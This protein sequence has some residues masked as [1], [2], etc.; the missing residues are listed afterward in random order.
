[1]EKNQKKS[2]EKNNIILTTKRIKNLS[3][4]IKE[5]KKDCNI[6]IKNYCKTDKKKRNILMSNNRFENINK[7]NQNKVEETLAIYTLQNIPK[8][9]SKENKGIQNKKEKNK[10]QNSLKP[11]NMNI[12]NQSKFHEENYL[13]KRY[14]KNNFSDIKVKKI[15]SNFNSIILNFKK[16]NHKY[17]YRLNDNKIKGN[18]TFI[19]NKEL[20][21]QDGKIG[22]SKKKQNK[23]KDCNNKKEIKTPFKNINGIN[24]G[25]FKSF[26][27]KKYSVSFVKEPFKIEQ[28]YNI[29]N[30]LKN[31]K[32]RIKWK[33]KHL[34]KS[35]E[36]K[37]FMKQKIKNNIIFSH[38]YT[39]R[40]KKK[41]DNSSHISKKLEIDKTKNLLNNRYQRT[42]YSSSFHKTLPITINKIKF[43]NNK[44]EKTNSFGRINSHKI[45][46]TNI[47][48]NLYKENENNWLT[49]SNEN[50]HIN[51]YNKTEKI[52]EENIID[53]EKAYLLEEKVFKIL[54][55]INE[56]IACDEECLN[57]I[58]F[59][60]G[61]NFYI[62]ELNLFKKRNNYKKIHNYSK[63]EIL[64]YCLCYDISLN[65]NFNKASILLKSII[66]ILHQNFLVLLEYFLYLSKNSNNNENSKNN[67]WKGKIEKIIEK[68]LKINL[69][70]QDLN[71][72]SITHLIFN[73]FK[74]ICNYY[75]MIID[76]L[77]SFEEN[78]KNKEDY[79]P[80]CLSLN[81]NKIN[82]KKKMNIISLFFIEANK[83]LNNYTFENMK[84][85]FYL[86]LN[87]QKYSFI[88][89]EQ[90][91][92]INE[93]TKFTKY[94]LAPIKQGFKYTLIINLDETLIYNDNNKIILRPNLFNF[95]SKVKEIYE[96]IAFSFYSNSIIDK[97]LDLIENKTKYF[98][99]ILYPDQL[100]INYNGKFVKDLDNLGRNLKH[101]IV[102]DSKVN[103]KKKFRNNLILIKGFYGDVSVD[104]NLL[105]ILAYLLQ[106][107]K[108]DN[109]EDDIRI[110][111]NK[112]KNS[113][114]SYLIE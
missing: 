27:I 72:D 98:D 80:D 103:I 19:F 45:L 100:T 74:N 35:F 8:N 67:I 84:L 48:I 85:F 4:N 17:K 93:E 110:R 57:W 44:K 34:T 89:K 43:K 49:S 94:Y 92:Y 20:Q 64:C 68:E 36:D 21:I 62:N 105:K 78:E 114:K 111:I 41:K 70:P 109:Y 39:Q 52:S 14:K 77:Y 9:I 53:L 82:K 104:I 79:F 58:D 6:P 5:M 83:S 33:E 12:F 87:N 54:K 32:D 75:E 59:Y 51:T 24:K 88:N 38:N 2:N 73:T 95:L 86:Y 65:Q 42:K 81:T 3:K 90:V 63:L 11:K 101:V 28:K 69:S 7:N 76:N 13:T 46:I 60:F 96:I 22:N 26:L 30:N 56:Y 61:T 1:M 108:T 66:N 10:E 31:V 18:N 50:S 112:Y 97:A 29:L 16:E 15:K 55:K 113:I 99:Y 23:I 102:V 25:Y 37:K 107:I 106:N 47:N 40:I 71:E 91:N